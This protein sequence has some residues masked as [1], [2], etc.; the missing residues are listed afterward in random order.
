MADNVILPGTGA[1][2]WTDEVG[3]N[4][5]QIIKL[6][7]GTNN[8]SGTVPYDATY[9]FKSDVTRIVPGVAATNLGKAHDS[10]FAPGDVGVLGLGVRS[11][12][13]S[14]TVSASGDYAS[15]IFGPTGRLWVSSG[16]GESVTATITTTSATGTYAVADVVGGLLTF[17]NAVRTNGGHSIVNS[18]K[19]CGVSAI[20]YE[21]WFFNADIATPAADNAVFALAA[22]DGLKFLGVVPIAAGDYNVAQTAFN[23]A[24]IKGCGLQ[25]KSTAATTTIYAYLKALAVTAP[26]TTT[27]Y[28]TV[29][30][31]YVD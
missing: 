18:V 15:F 6:A 17:A 5:A 26:G 23:N 30:F 12:L 3:G 9:G 21:L 31:E 4:H 25:V 7:D 10:V 1:P 13:P 19:L 22:A 27:I 14:G 11:D 2:V 29:D 28:L 24:T 16:G 20:P 8:S